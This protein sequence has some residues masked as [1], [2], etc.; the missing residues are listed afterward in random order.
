[1]KLLAVYLDLGKDYENFCKKTADE[2]MISSQQ[3]T[4]SVRLSVLDA[5]NLER[6][7]VPTLVKY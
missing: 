6:C 5:K 2:L 7:T 3:G 4:S 1:M